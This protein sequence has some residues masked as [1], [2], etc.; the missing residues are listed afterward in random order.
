MQ[1][2]AIWPNRKI[3]HIHV[4]IHEML[5]YINTIGF[6]R[7]ALSLHLDAQNHIFYS[8]PNYNG[9]INLNCNAMI[10]TTLHSYNYIKMQRVDSIIKIN[11]FSWKL[12]HWAGINWY[13]NLHIFRKLLTWCNRLR[14]VNVSQGTLIYAIA[15]TPL[16]TLIM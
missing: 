4:K 6:S 10:W 8:N 12:L 2:L 1:T 7:K 5:T 16:Y 9:L 11:R 14:C 3:H 15:Y 13:E